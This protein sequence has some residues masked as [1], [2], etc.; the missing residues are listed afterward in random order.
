MRAVAERLVLA[1]PTTAQ[2]H[3]VLAGRDG[4][5]VAEMIDDSDRALGIDDCGRAP[6]AGRSSINDQVERVSKAVLDFFGRPG[7]RFALTIRTGAGYGPD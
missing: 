2:C 6:A 3:R 5:L 4:K 1:F 7:W